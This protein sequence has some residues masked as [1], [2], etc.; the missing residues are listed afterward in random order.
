MLKA[1]LFQ[2]VFSDKEKF[3]QE[4]MIAPCPGHPLTC[5]P[6]G[7]IILQYV[8]YFLRTIEENDHG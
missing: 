6:S 1:E 5:L 2:V 4:V 8:S 3:S 7:H